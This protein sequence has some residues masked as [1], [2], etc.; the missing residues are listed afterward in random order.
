M[1]VHHG[2]EVGHLAQGFTACSIDGPVMQV[3]Q[4]FAMFGIDTNVDFF[5]VGFRQVFPPGFL[6]INRGD[7]VQA[8]V[9]GHQFAHPE[10]RRHGMCTAVSKATGA[11]GHRL[12]DDIQ[13]LRA[14]TKVNQ[15]GC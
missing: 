9:R 5:A 11:I 15:D 6:E 13:I 8:H 10:V 12:A 14:A 7:A 3:M 1:Q 4:L 2:L